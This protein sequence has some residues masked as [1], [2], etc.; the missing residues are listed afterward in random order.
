VAVNAAIRVVAVLLLAWEPLNFA[1]RG[2]SVLPTLAYRSWMA[3]AE[4][5][6]HGLVA[7]CCAAAGMLLWNGAPDAR[8]LAHLAI[9]LSV[10]RVIQSLYWSALPGNTVPGD[11]W[12]HAL[13]AVV[14]GATLSAVIHLS[15]REPSARPSR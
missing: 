15:G 1:L 8:R 14:A 5:A 12:F 4:L 11:E 7:V 10:A 13:I 6:V 3:G 9:V 2:L